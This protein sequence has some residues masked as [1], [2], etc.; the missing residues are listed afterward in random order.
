[1]KEWDATLWID[2]LDGDVNKIPG[3]TNHIPFVFHDV[4]KGTKYN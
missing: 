1:M 3:D 2:G 4:E